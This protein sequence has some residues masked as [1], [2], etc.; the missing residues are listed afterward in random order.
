MVVMCVIVVL[1]VVKT[2]FFM[3]IYK[4]F[5]PIVIMMSKVIYDLRA[6]GVVFAVVILKFSLMFCVIGVGLGDV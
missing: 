5:T 1:L 6:F 4:S 3:R 2:L